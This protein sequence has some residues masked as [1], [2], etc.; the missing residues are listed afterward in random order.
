MT[1]TTNTSVSTT[2]PCS[3]LPPPPKPNDIA[4]SGTFLKSAVKAIVRW[5][6]NNGLFFAKADAPKFIP[7]GIKAIRDAA[8]EL[9]SE[10]SSSIP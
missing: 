5:W 8:T 4:S 2:F 1:T 6:A 9:E 10:Y 3:T 7:A